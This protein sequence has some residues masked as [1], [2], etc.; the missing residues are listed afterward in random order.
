[1]KQIRSR[2]VFCAVAV[3]ATGPSIAGESA[4][5]GE[6]ARPTSDLVAPCPRCLDKAAIIDI[7]RV[8][9]KQADVVYLGEPT[10]EILEDFPW[11][12]G[13]GLRWSYTTDRPDPVSGLRTFKYRGETEESADEI[14]SSPSLTWR[15]R[16]QTGWLRYG[17][18]Q[19]LVDAG[20]L[21]LEALS[22][23]PQKREGSFLIHALTGQLAMTIDW[24]I[25]DDSS[26]FY[27][28]HERARLAAKERAG[29]WLRYVAGD[30]QQ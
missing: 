18:I 12:G 9:L 23:P 29:Y 15:V 14:L 22:W 16:Y 1:M 26:E 19:E 24:F 5:H 13:R 27:L 17:R 6:S 2:I 11:R 10:A 30:L 25:E 21:P 7:A 20:T 3:L 28:R 4:T 8:Y